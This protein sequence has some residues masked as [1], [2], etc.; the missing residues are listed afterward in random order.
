MGAGR[1]EHRQAVICR[2]LEQVV[3][4]VTVSV[5]SPPA[6]SGEKGDGGEFGFVGC[7]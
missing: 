3:Q 6:V 1:F 7:D 4:V 5:E 2:P